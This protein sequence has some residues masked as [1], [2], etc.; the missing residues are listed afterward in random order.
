MSPCREL[1]SIVACS[2]RMPPAPESSLFFARRASLK[3]SNS[4]NHDSSASVA[5]DSTKGNSSTLLRAECGEG[6]AAKDVGAGNEPDDG[7]EERGERQA[8]NQ[9]RPGR[10]PIHFNRPAT[11]RPAEDGAPAGADDAR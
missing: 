1:L 5:A 4:M 3:A 7:D 10:M 6:L 9:L 11:D 8:E 2:G